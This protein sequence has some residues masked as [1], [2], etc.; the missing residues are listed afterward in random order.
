MDKVLELLC[1]NARCSVK[2][3]AAQAGMSE[4]AVEET[5]MRLEMEGVVLGYNTVVDPEKTI[6]RGV[7]AF[8]EVKTTPD[9]GGFE[10]LA[11]R[12]SQYEQ[13]RGCYLMSGGYDLA[14]VIEGKDLY[15]V[16]SFVAEKLAP[17]DGVLSTATH[18]QLRVYKHEHF[19]IKGGV[20]RE[21][22]PVSP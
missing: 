15:E 5:I 7:T 21:R 19:V 13:V 9:E 11:R 14:V 6:D 20:Q 18:F 12:I 2:E 8:I 22:L 1:A 3:L 4:S 10:R 17:L 16:A